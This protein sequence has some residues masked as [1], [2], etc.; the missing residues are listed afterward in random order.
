MSSTNVNSSKNET[1]AFVVCGADKE[2]KIEGKGVHDFKGPF[3]EKEIT[4]YADTAKTAT[5]K[6]RTIPMSCE[7][8]IAKRDAKS[9]NV[10]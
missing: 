8:R 1:L 7:K 4:V 5:L 3:S 10:R 9:E 6:R 2:L